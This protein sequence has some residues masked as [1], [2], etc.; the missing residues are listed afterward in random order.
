MSRAHV[1][2]ATFPAQGHINPALQFAKRLANADIQVTFFTSVYAWRRMSRTAAGSNGLINF[3]SFSDGYDDGLQPGDD[4]KNYMSEMKSRGIKALSDTLAANNVDQ[5]SSKITFVVY[6]HLFAW[7]AKVAREFHLRSALLWIEPATVLDI[8]YFYFNGYS[9]EIDA[10]SDAIHLPGGLPVLA[11]RDLPSFLLP[12][13]HERF[14][15]LM[16]EKLETLEGEEKPKVLVNSFDALEPDAL[17]AIDKYEMIAIGPLI[18]SAFLDGKDPSD[19]SFG[20]DLFEKGS[21]DDDCLEWLSTN[22]RSSVVYVSF[23]SF[24]N[25]TKSQMEEIAR[26]LLDCG[27]PFLWVVRVNEG[28]EVLISCMEELKRVGKIVSWCSQLEVLTHPSLGCF[29]T[30]CG[31]NSTLESISFGVP[32]V[33]FPQWFD[34]GTNAKLMED[35]WRTGVRV[36]ANEEGSVVDG[37]EIR[38]CIEE[39]MDGGEKSRKLR[40]SAGKWKDLARKAMEEDGSSV[41][42][43]KVFLDEVV[44]I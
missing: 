18:P 36:R 29:V 27:R 20:G 24:V 44:G 28:E 13:T 40:E 6:S 1:L 7:A 43:L 12:S 33:A 19:R 21:N 34:Q 2:L 17:K 38:R 35:V 41:N 25:T 16:K 30:H 32:M 15:S 4:G 5:K 10:G 3:V 14:R 37:D 26:G 8:F 11:Q 23:G 31:W 39:V 42:N 9:D 22:P